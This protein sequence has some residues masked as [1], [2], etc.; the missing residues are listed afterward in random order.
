LEKKKKDSLLQ[1]SEN[2]LRVLLK[3]I[4]KNPKYENSTEIDKMKW[5]KY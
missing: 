2:Y 1:N 4:L 5:K 3:E